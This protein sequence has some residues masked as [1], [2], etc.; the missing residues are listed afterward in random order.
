MKLDS[1]GFTFYRISSKVKAP[2]YMLDDM[3]IKSLV[4]P[5]SRTKTEDI[6]LFTTYGQTTKEDVYEY[7]K[8]LWNYVMPEHANMEN[9]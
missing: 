8:C 4:P 3:L 9:N 7:L 2:T 6:H 1:N 5:K